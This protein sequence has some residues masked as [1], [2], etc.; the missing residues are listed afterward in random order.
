MS[1]LLD[2]VVTTYVK[3]FSAA[4]SR[5][6]ADIFCVEKEVER[7]I[8]KEIVEE[9]LDEIEAEAKRREKERAAVRELDEFRDVLIQCVL[10]ALLVGLLGSH[11]YGWLDAMFYQPESKTRSGFVLFGASCFLVF[12]LIILFKVYLKKLFESFNKFMKA[13]KELKNE[14]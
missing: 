10:L 4:D 2:E 6:D 1:R 14:K 7:Q 9:R 3:N 13:R 8:V 5:S 12:T 11:L